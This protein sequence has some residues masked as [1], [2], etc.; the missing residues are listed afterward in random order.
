MMNIMRVQKLP[1]QPA[2][3][4]AMITDKADEE[5]EPDTPDSYSKLII[6][7]W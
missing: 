7:L 2:L 6:L 5:S 1:L 4:M 3:E